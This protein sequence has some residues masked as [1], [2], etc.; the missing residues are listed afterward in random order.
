MTTITIDWTLTIAIYAAVV[1]TCTLLW[2]CWKWLHAGPNLHVTAQADMMTY[3]MPQFGREAVMVLNATNRDDR[4]TT[5]THF[6][7]HGYKN[8]WARFRR[9]ST[10]SGVVNVPHDMHPP[11]YVL[12]PGGTWTGLCRQDDVMVKLDSTGLVYLAI[13]HSHAKRPVYCRVH[14]TRAD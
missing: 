7:V 8:W 5:I 13:I 6:T 3:N 14:P 11:P 1:A 2:D 10:F 4:P 12:S 9:R